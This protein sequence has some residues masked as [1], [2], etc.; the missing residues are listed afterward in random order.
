MNRKVFNCHESRRIK[1]RAATENSIESSFCLV[2]FA[3]RYLLSQT[4]WV[5]QLMASSFSPFS[6]SHRQIYHLWYCGILRQQWLIKNS[7]RL[8]CLIASRGQSERRKNRLHSMWDF[9]VNDDRTKIW[10]AVFIHFWLV[11]EQ[12]E[13]SNETCVYLDNR[14]NTK[15]R[16]EKIARSLWK[17]KKK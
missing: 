12:F 2:S 7:L 1:K 15:K 10:I 5:M 8:I 11:R 16:E 4:E 17:D 9:N 6:F 13:K 14:K 3:S